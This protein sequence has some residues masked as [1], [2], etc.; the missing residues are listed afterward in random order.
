MAPSAQWRRCPV[1][2]LRRQRALY[3]QRVVAPARAA[4]PCSTSPAI[5]RTAP[6]WEGACAREGDGSAHQGRRERARARRRAD[7][8]S[9]APAWRAELDILLGEAGDRLAFVTLPKA[10]SAADVSRFLRILRAEA[11]RAD[12]RRNDPGKHHDRNTGRGARGLVDRRAPRRV[13]SSTSEPSTSSART[14]ARYRPRRWSAP[15]SSI[16][17]WCA[18]RSARWS[19]PRSRTPWYRRTA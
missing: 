3:P 8:R 16:I 9:V 7:P 2:S 1:R 5:A 6:P 17:R 18:M 10:H 13:E 12:L 11:L 15:A 4:D 19:Q 14:T